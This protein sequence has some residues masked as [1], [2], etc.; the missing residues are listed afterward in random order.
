M[1]RASNSNVVYR[2]ICYVGQQ[3]STGDVLLKDLSWRVDNVEFF[4]DRDVAYFYHNP[5]TEEVQC[6]CLHCEAH[7]KGKIVHHQVSKIK[8]GPAGLVSKAYLKKYVREQNKSYLALQGKLRNGVFEL[9]KHE[10]PKGI[11][12][13]SYIPKVGNTI[14]IWL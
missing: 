11:I 3:L 14:W 7:N 8:L 13:V 5:Q 6:I 12:T 10:I 1:D 9:K 4:I 2:R